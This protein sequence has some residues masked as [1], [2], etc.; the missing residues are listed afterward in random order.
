MSKKK[1]QVEFTCG[2]CQ[3]V[4]TPKVKAG[5]GVACPECGSS[6]Q[7]SSRTVKA[8]DKDADE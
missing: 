7:L 2:A 4:F 6:D 8:E 1:E 5:E 3:H